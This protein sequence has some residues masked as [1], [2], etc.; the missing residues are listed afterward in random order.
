MADRKL[1]AKPLV[2]LSTS[3]PV[4]NRHWATATVDRSLAQRVEEL[5]AAKTAV[6]EN[7]FSG[8]VEEL[9]ASKRALKD[10]NFSACVEELHAAKTAL[11]DKMEETNAMDAGGYT[12]SLVKE[13]EQLRLHVANLQLRLCAKTN[14]G[15]GNGDEQFRCTVRAR[16]RD[17]PETGNTSD[18]P[19][20]D[21]A[22]KN[23]VK[24]DEA[25]FAA[26]KASFI[27]G[28]GK[29][30]ISKLCSD[31]TVS[32]RLHAAVNA[33]GITPRLSCTPIEEGAD[34]DS[35]GEC[36]GTDSD[37]DS[38]SGLGSD[39]DEV[40]EMPSVCATRSLEEPRVAKAARVKASVTATR[41]EPLV[42]ISPYSPFR[43]KSSLKFCRRG[44]QSRS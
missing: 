32:A 17:M 12:V 33:S 20:S 43:R 24:L 15:D 13:T 25:A 26:W 37:S 38:D 23:T 11:R 44:R 8:S 2:F 9:H 35:D 36:S 16:R 5:H 28:M 14:R 34:A 22:A 21:A 30:Q 4:L 1:R 10:N 3:Q 31:D 6:R 27:Y 7:R 29:A 41:S 40:V 18:D 42:R 19:G 39:S